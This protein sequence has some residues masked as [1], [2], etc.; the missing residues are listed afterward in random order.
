MKE[1]QP[2]NQYILVDIT[3]NPAEQKTAGGIIIPD[4]VKEK[5]ETGKVISLS[6]IDSVEIEVGDT[7]LYKK[8]SGTETEFEGKKFLLIPYADILAKIVETEEI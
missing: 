1:L 5:P 3:E 2:V 8:Y 6:K 4:T 7:V